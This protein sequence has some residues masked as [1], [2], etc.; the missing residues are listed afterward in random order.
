MKIIRHCQ[1]SFIDLLK[2]ETQIE[3]AILRSALNKVGGRMFLQNT[4][5]HIPDYTVSQPRRLHFEYVI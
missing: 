2:E 1:L 4:S 3:F 5:K